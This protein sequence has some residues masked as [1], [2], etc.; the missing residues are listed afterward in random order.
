MD[1]THNITKDKKLK[2]VLFV[3]IS[4]N[5]CNFMLS[6]AFIRNETAETYEILFDLFSQTFRIPDKIMIDRAPGQKKALSR[7]WPDCQV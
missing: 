1:S 7:V 6:A 2:F 3:G 4:E 5:G